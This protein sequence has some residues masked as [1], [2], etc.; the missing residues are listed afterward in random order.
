MI[1]PEVMVMIMTVTEIRKDGHTLAIVLYPDLVLTQ[2][3][4][5]GMRI[6]TTTETGIEAK[7]ATGILTILTQ[8]TATTTAAR[9]AAML[10][11]IA[12]ETTAATARAEGMRQII[13][14]TSKGMAAP[15]WA[16]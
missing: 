4:I 9:E 16:V 8:A 13:I 7:S 12:I 10:A 11:M 6:A 15:A 14:D 2:A 5:A 3:A 1:V